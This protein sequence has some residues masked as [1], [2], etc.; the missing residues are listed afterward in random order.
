[1]RK[2]ELLFLLGILYAGMA[3]AQTRLTGKVLSEADGTPLAGVSVTIKDTRISVVT[4]IDG[5]FS[6]PS[7]ADTRV[8]LVITHV[9]FKPVE[10]ASS[11]NGVYR[12]GET[13]TAL[14][15]V[16]ITGYTT[17]SRRQSSGATSS[18]SID[19][20]RKQTFGSF[21]QALQGQAPGVSVV[22]N[23]GQPGANAVVRIRGNGSISG[24]NA[25]LYIMDG[26]EI[27]AADFASVNQ[28]DFDKVEVLK[29]AAASA[30]Y[31]SRGANGVIVISTRKGRVGQMQLNYDVQVGTSDLPKDRLIM[32]NSAQKIDYEL[33]RGNPFAWTAAQADS[34][35]KVN[36]S[37]KDALFHRGVTQQHMLSASGGTQAS[38]YYASLSYMDQDG[39]LKTTGLKR[40]TGRINVDNNIKNWKFG[41]N[42]QGGYSKLIG[43]SE[44]NTTTA[45]PLNAIRWSNPYERDINPLTHNYQQTGG[46]GILTSGQPNAAMQLFLN[47]NY[48]LQ[49]KGIA[50]SYLQFDF[51][52]MP[53]LS[54]RTNW[55]IDYTQNETASYVDPRV[56]S[57][58]STQGSLNR[59]LNRNLRYT[60]TTSINYKKTFGK[61][62]IEAGVFT[63]VVKA[64]Y[65]SFGFTGYG[66]TNGFTNE[67]GITAGSAT[68]TNYIPAVTGSG[69]MNGILSYFANINYGYNSKYYVTLSGRR[70]GSSRF[71]VNN[72][73]ANFGAVGATWLASDEE[74]LKNATWI[75][76]LKLR[77]SVGTTGNQTGTPAGDY[78]I[79]IFARAT[80][81]GVSG[82]SPSS[83]GNLDYSWE[84]NRS[85][86]F[87]LDF[88][89]LNN[90]ITGAVDL[91]D[92]ET[93]DLFYAVPIDP[94]NSGFTSIPSNFGKLRNRGIELMLRGD[95][96]SNQKFRW[97]LEGNLTYNLNRVIDLPSDSVISGTTILA[98]KKPV[99]SLYLVKYAGVNPDNGNALY[100][101]RN[102][103]TTPT[104]SVND[105]VI[106]GTSDAPLFGGLSTTVNY[107][108]FDLSAQ[109]NF[110]LKRVLYNND[111]NNVTN[112]QYF[113][114]NMTVDVLREWQ[115][116]GDITDVPRPAASG[117]NA[118]QTQTTRFLDD[119]SFWRLR[120]VMLGYNLSSHVTSLLK[121]RS[122]RVFVQGQN[123]WTSTK[124]RG[125]DPEVTGTSLTGAQ[126]PALI[127]TTVGLNVGF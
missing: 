24:G 2:W 3:T 78:P 42:M 64:N 20:V 8:K 114:D 62:E 6:I 122:A 120:N 86:N 48:T 97:T 10:V 93:R 116:A 76:V 32:M 63:E 25:P 30:L 88:A 45:T 85:V 104:Y 101:K 92:R 72:R 57:G 41:L 18:I 56:S 77:A 36:F 110:F 49:L 22:A 26:I 34:L 35:R 102:G 98:E 1:M 61:H 53:G 75:N 99:N 21:D 4:G 119:A 87:G 79:P 115:K 100:Y 125:F 124:F 80:Y 109:M 7:T 65:R 37:W 47:Y 17:L 15:E 43:T 28:G 112:P 14:N 13:Q 90:R 12:I 29:D 44:A 68:N 69:T 111:R 71:G 59:A 91:Y 103:S 117:G 81:A 60:G 54:A 106:L 50:S 108:G 89:I 40:Y 27:S 58:Q 16:I 11:P 73:F 39:I 121:I 94:S 123:L 46:P 5:S 66:F 33:R 84:V 95:V 113:T 70:D 127:Q 23:S 51:P 126:Y 107:M 67:A 55:G 9:G 96:V 52:F 83:P 105:K 74:F 38:R 31:G 82:W 118:Y 19:D